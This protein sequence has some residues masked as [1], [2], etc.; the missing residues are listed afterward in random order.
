MRSLA[1]DFREAI[2]RAVTESEHTIGSGK[3]Q[4]FADYKRMCG[5]QTGLRRALDIFNET[6]KRFQDDD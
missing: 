1:S 3:A 2:G 4:D 6:L 5:E